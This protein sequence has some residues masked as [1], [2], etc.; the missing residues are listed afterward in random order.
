PDA[1]L[2]AIVYKLVP[3]LYENELRRR[4]AFYRLHPEMAA[5][6]TPEQRGEDTEYLIFS[7]SEKISLSLEYAEKELAEDNEELLKAKYLLCPAIFSIGMLKKFIIY[8]YGISERQFCVEIMYKVKTIILPDYYTLMDVAYIY[9]W[10]RDAPMKYYYRIRTTETNPVEL[11]EVP[12]RRSPS[13][14]GAGQQRSATEDDEDDK[15]NVHHLEQLVSEGG[16]SESDSNSSSNRRRPEEGNATNVEDMSKSITART[17]ATAEVTPKVESPADA[18]SPVPRKNESIKLKIGLNKNKYVSFL[19]SPQADVPVSSPALSSSESLDSPKPHKSEKTKR[20]RTDAL[21]ALQQMEENSR[22]LKIKIEKIKDMG[23]VSSMSK[24]EAKSAKKQQQLAMAS[25]PYKVE[26]SPGITQGLLESK[27]LHSS[28][29]ASSSSSSSS[30]PSSGKLKIKS[31]KSGRSSSG[32]GS[33]GSSPEDTRHHHPIVLKI[34]QRSPDMATATLKFGVSRKADKSLTLSP[35]PPLP[36]SPPTPPPAKKFED[37]KSQFLNSFELAPIK[38]PQSGDSSVPVQSPKTPVPVE[39]AAAPSKK[40]SPPA[41]TPPSNGG[42]PPQQGKRKAK[43]ATGSSRSGPKKP[44]LSDDELK[45]FVEKTVA[46]NIRS[47]SEHI[48]PPMFLKPRPPPATTPPS[49]R[50]QQLSPPLPP[51]LAKKEHHK[52]PSSKRDSPRPFAFKAPA[53]PPP[54]PIVSA[55]NIPAPKPSQ[56]VLPAPI[57]QKHSLTPIRPAITPKPATK[58]SPPQLAHAPARKPTTPTKLPTSSALAPSTVGNN[59]GPVNG[60]STGGGTGNATTHSVA[61]GANKLQKPFELKRAQSNPSINIPPPPQPPPVPTVSPPAMPRDTEISKLRPEDLKKTG[62][63]VYGPSTPVEP[64][65]KATSSK[66]PSTPNFAVPAKIAPKPSVAVTTGSTTKT[67]SQGAKARPVNYLNYALF[68]SKAA[69]A[70]SRTPIPSYSSN[71]PSYSPDSPQ[72]NP[73]LN[74]SPKQF[75]YA[76][77]LAY[78]S[79]LQNMLNDRKSGGSTSPPS[80]T[81][82]IPASSPPGQQDAVSSSVSVSIAPVTV[83]TN[84]TASTNKRPAAALS[85]DAA[86]RKLQPPEKQAMLVGVDKLPKDLSV[87]L[88]T[89]EYEATRANNQQKQLE[90]NF[91]EIV[92]LPDITSELKLPRT[93]VAAASPSPPDRR[94]PPGTKG[95]SATAGPNTARK[96]SPVNSIATTANNSSVQ[97][98]NSS[99]LISALGAPVDTF[100]RKFHD[101]VDK[102][103]GEGSKTIKPSAQKAPTMPAVSRPST[104]KVPAAPSITTT[105]ASNKFKHP[106]ATVLDN[107]T[108]KMN[109]YREVDLIP[110]G[111]GSIVVTGSGAN[112]T[113]TTTTNTKSSP[114]NP[115]ARMMPPPSPIPKPAIP[116]APKP[117]LQT[118]PNGRMAISPPI[119]RSP[120]ATGGGGPGGHH[121]PKSK[122]P[123]SSSSHLPSMAS[124]GPMFDFQMKSAAIGASG[125]TPSKKPPTGASST[126]LTTSANLPRRKIVPMNNSTSLVPLKSSPSGLSPSAASSSSSSC[127][128]SSPGSGGGSKVPPGSSFSD[129]ITLHPQGPVPAAQAPAPPRNQQP[130]VPPHSPLSQLLIDNLFARHHEVN[131]NS[132]LYPYI[133]HQFAQQQ[134]QNQSNVNV[135]IGMGPG[136]VTITASPM[137]STRNTLSQN[138]LT[139]TAIP[140]GSS[141]P[142]GRGGGSGGGVSGGGAPPRGPN[143]STRNGS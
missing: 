66:P 102:Q 89:D 34:D 1:P 88:A 2:Q 107:G 130:Y 17:V 68:N 13:L 16:S 99:P 96:P 91:I 7:P 121:Q 30:T 134:S 133:L 111:G 3:G 95:S 118:F 59:N 85:P 97:A 8:K 101:V 23:L 86:D 60:A 128:S 140:P 109:N 20:K 132:V 80:T 53:P 62:V 114:T 58:P 5:I 61:T 112:T 125:G 37:E 119:Q 82:T 32:S 36:P 55:N 75:K 12:L 31:P 84:S 79:H 139:V 115:S 21:A 48:V 11:P 74:F 143:P 131:Y 83:T 113:T 137:G 63:K 29:N 45:A 120:A 44:K 76:N 47:P 81:I 54:P 71:S 124:M 122:T 94:T 26:L 50:Q 64:P 51:S 108:F 52:Q 46:E 28:K 9:T 129:Y 43:D 14:V 24:R 27:R 40:T 87:T 4:R 127:S 103:N 19:Q 126:T 18:P 104:P 38:T 110:K 56:Q 142:G 105:S 90:N 117:P 135:P 141:V 72:Y 100:Q 49:S 73:N 42:S 35:S 69:A 70:G 57:P 39:S 98:K 92:A 77:P 65:T 67:T 33:S 106:N 136:S 15:E 22:E 41:T 78:N 116:I 93:T 10:K 138:S 25:A 123:P 6:A